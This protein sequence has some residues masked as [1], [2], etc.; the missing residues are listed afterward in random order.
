MRRY[1]NGQL[2]N[3]P[4]KKNV[5]TFL[6]GIR[7]TIKA[8]LGLSAAE[9]IDRLNPKI[10]GWANYHRHAVSKR[11]FQRVDAAI[12]RSLWQWCPAKT[13][14][15]IPRLAQTEVLWATGT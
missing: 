8:S 14:R 13:S 7:K 10:R 6:D 11:V 5:K 15:K 9:L 4:S 1:P 3:K 12:F 2:L